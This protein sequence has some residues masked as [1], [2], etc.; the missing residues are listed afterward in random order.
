MASFD[1]PERDI[2]TI[3]L[4][5]WGRVV[6]A[7]GTVPWLLLDPGGQPVEPVVRFLRDFVASGNT[8]GSVRS[9]AYALQVSLDAAKATLGQL[10]RTTA[11]GSGRRTPGHADHPRPLK[12]SRFTRFPGRANVSAGR[13]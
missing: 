7:S 8:A 12:N 11:A 5:H 4:E 9:Y 13:A 6:P 3:R 10:T 1:H 2:A